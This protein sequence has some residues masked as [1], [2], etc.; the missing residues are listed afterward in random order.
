MSDPKE[1]SPVNALAVKLNAGHDANGNPRRGWAVIDLKTGD[2][3]DFVDEGY[4]GRAA[5]ERVY[6]RVLLGP[7]FPTTPATYRELKREAERD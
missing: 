3:V 7:E 2:M 6:P 1:W 5:L 4:R